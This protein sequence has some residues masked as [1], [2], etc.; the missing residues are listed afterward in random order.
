MIDL[1]E[2]PPAR[3]EVMDDFSVTGAVLE[4]ALDELRL[5][6]RWLGGHRATWQALRPALHVRPALHEQPPLHVL[7]VGTG[8]ADGPEDLVRRMARRRRRIRVTA[9][10]AN[11]ATVAHARRLLDARLPAPQ[12]ALVEVIKGDALALP[13]PDDAFDVATASLFLHHFDGAEAV[14]VLREMRR[15][16]RRGLVVNDLHRHRLAYYAIR[17]VA[18]LLPVSPMFAHDAPLSV[19]RGFRRAELHALADDAGLA[20]ARVRWH[21]AFRWTLST[22]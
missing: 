20:P 2:R 15:V 16:S 8:A 13:F 5:V 1:R 22:I 10:D 7:D 4:Q 17:A 18:A 21:W 12:R 11:P 3:Q 19:R 9:L 6:N 14:R